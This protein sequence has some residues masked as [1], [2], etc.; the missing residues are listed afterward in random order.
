MLP[1]VGLSVCVPCP[2]SAL[3]SVFQTTLSNRSFS[4]LAFACLESSSRER[5][6]QLGTLFDPLIIP[7]PFP[8]SGPPPFP[9]RWNR[10]ARRG[11]CFSL[12]LSF[13]G[14]FT[15]WSEVSGV[16]VWCAWLEG[17]GEH[18][19]CRLRDE[20]KP[21]PV[22][23]SLRLGPSLQGSSTCKRGW[24]GERERR[25]ET[26]REEGKRASNSS[27]VE[28]D[29]P[30][31]KKRFWRSSRD[32]AR[33]DRYRSKSGIHID[34]GASGRERGRGERVCE[35]EGGGGGKRKFR[36]YPTPRS[37]LEESNRR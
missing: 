17:E 29:S 2:S 11:R 27:H 33:K 23:D 8:G 37:H 36:L 1:D 30:D 16:K 3:P 24:E 13:F 5:N 14:P 34:F 4:L 35:R 26:E 9:R 18:L 25:R 28:M 22:I 19:R 12:S 6:G 32:A 10:S 7:L 21:A 15:P 20:A 31:G